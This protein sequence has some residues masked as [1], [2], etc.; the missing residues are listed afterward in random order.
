[1]SAAQ[2]PLSAMAQLK[3]DRER[4]SKAPALDA[5]SGKVWRMAEVVEVVAAEGDRVSVMRMAVDDFQRCLRSYRNLPWSVI[6]VKPI[7]GKEGACR[8]PTATSR[9][10]STAKSSRCLSRK[11]G[12]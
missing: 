12:R 2:R 5:R 1:M 3:L 10:A 11:K 9:D 6:A 7:L 8:S 4:A